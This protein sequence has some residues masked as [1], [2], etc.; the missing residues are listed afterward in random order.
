MSFF[1]F[2]L[3][4]GQARRPGPGP[5]TVPRRELPYPS[6]QAADY[7]CT[8]RM[9]QKD[10]TWPA[11][12]GGYQSTCTIP[13]LLHSP[14]GKKD[15]TQH[16]RVSRTGS[17]VSRLRPLTLRE[18]GMTLCV[19]MG[20][21]SYGSHLSSTSA[22]TPPTQRFEKD[23]SSLGMS[24]LQGSA[25]PFSPAAPAVRPLP[26]R[27][28]HPSL[29]R[30]LRLPVSNLV[31]LVE[32]VVKPPHDGRL[33]LTPVLPYPWVT[34][35]GWHSPPTPSLDAKNAGWFLCPISTSPISVHFSRP[36]PPLVSA[37][38]RPLPQRRTGIPLK[39]CSLSL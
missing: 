15:L 22:T 12:V 32:M 18:A 19:E 28:R 21:F 39:P 13:A 34:T 9:D 29:P 33:L 35:S 14:L 31:D 23:L 30:A 38:E 27:E 17:P 36:P 37:T 25:A 5:H 16:A 8:S 4:T 3:Q 20:P 10:V 11:L 7:A 2:S 6:R 24:H 1:I 26:T